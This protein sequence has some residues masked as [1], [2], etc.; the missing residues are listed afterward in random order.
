VNSRPDILFVSHRIPFPPDK[1]GR[2]RSFHL[3]RQLGRYANVHLASLT[4]SA[5]DPETTR[6][7]SGECVQFAAFSVSR[8]S[9][10]HALRSLAFGGTMSAGASRSSELST[11]IRQWATGTRFAAAVA[12][13]ASVAHYLRLP[14]LE[15]ART[16]IDMT[17]LES[18]RRSD[19]AA[20]TWAPKSSAFALE[21]ARLGHLEKSICTWAK[22]VTLASHWEAATLREQSGKANVHAIANGVDLQCYSPSSPGAEAGCVFTGDL[23]YGP[24]IE[25]AGWFARGVWPNVR[26]RWPEVRFTVLGRKIGPAA[27]ELADIPGVDVV[28]NVT[29]VRPYLDRAAVVVASQQ[30]PR[31]LQ[32]SVLEAMAV[33]KPVVASPGALSGFGNRPDLPAQAPA[34]QAQ[35]VETILSLLADQQ[36]R[37]HLGR[38][39]RAYV[40]QH[41]NWST[42]LRPFARYLGLE[43]ADV[44]GRA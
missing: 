42:C 24:D 29:D 37:I 9:A 1:P 7:L 38:A 18:L 12:S 17:S 23:S 32:N 10:I 36:A 39:G 43:D 13:A 8:W 4:D 30:V 25:G 2:S 3:I 16:L 35:W 11:T 26:Q 40:E 22:A 27:K 33:G 31:G 5:V 41:H 19:E 20:T 6:Y 28:G 15:S 34:D 21:G 44:R 14:G